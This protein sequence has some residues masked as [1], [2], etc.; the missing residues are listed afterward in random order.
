MNFFLREV[1][2]LYLYGGGEAYHQPNDD[3]EH[4]NFDKV[5]STTAVLVEL[6]RH[7]DTL[8]RLPG[9]IQR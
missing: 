6:I 3:P 5:A 2:T 4:I 1:P 8:E 9:T 7:S